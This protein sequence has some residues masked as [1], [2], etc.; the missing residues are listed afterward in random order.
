MYVVWLSLFGRGGFT[1]HVA[2][3]CRDMSYLSSTS[4]HGGIMQTLYYRHAQTALVTAATGEKGLW[5]V[6]YSSGKVR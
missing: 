6:W 4:D 1:G 5:V 2:I 3:E